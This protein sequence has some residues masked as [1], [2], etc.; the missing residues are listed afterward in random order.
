M[1]GSRHW[2][3]DASIAIATISARV[4]GASGRY[5]CVPS[6]RMIPRLQRVSTA[7]YVGSVEGT[8]VNGKLSA[9]A[10]EQTSM[11]LT[12]NTL[13][14]PI[15]RYEILPSGAR[16]IYIGEIEKWT[17]QKTLLLI[18]QNFFYFSN[19]GGIF[20]KKVGSN[21]V[22]GI[23]I[24]HI[25]GSMERKTTYRKNP[26]FEIR[27]YRNSTESES[28]ISIS[29]GL[30]YL[31]NNF[32]FIKIEYCKGFGYFKRILEHIRPTPKPLP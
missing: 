9:C 2:S 11:T 29:I 24:P 28:L 18:I 14:C 1:L 16:A 32:Y 26:E 8:S 21:P 6:S 30:S 17:N 22:D 13:I 4:A 20:Y 12:I 19:L 3:Q 10:C 25:H 15:H 27:K 7:L 23:L 31:Q 5:I